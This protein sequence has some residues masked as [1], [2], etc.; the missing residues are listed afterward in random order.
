[1]ADA[2]TRSIPSN[3]VLS[4]KGE[5]PDYPEPGDNSPEAVALRRAHLVQSGTLDRIRAAAGKT[6]RFTPKGTK[7]R[8]RKATPTVAVGDL[9]LLQRGLIKDRYVEVLKLMGTDKG[10]HP[11]R[12]LIRVGDAEIAVKLADVDLVSRPLKASDR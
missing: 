7:Q 2:I 4:R 1:M 6:S 9:V 12:I 8:R 5:R 11:S 3:V 10:G